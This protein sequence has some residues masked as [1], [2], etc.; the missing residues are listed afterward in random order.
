MK[1]LERAS[2]QN[3][4][5]QSNTILK[6]SQREVQIENRSFVARI[7]SRLHFETQGGALV[8]FSVTLPVILLL[9]TGIFSFSMALYQKLQMAEAVSAAGRV[10]AVDRGDTD[11][12]KTTAAALYAAAPLLSKSNMTI[13]FTLNG[14]PVGSGVTTCS[15]TT[16]MISGQPAQIVATYPVG[17]GVYGK[18]FGTFNLG[19]QIT[20][21]VQ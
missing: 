19:T 3:A 1:T 8:E 20:E 16:N 9:M 2:T 11:P 18:N 10:L 4:K 7:S 15:G 21:V 12:C 6:L 13:S 14:V 17:V 5:N